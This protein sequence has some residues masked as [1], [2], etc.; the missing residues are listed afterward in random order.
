MNQSRHSLPFKSVA[1]FLAFTTVMFT[2]PVVSADPA[3][4]ELPTG[5]QSEFGN[6]SYSVNGNV[7][8][9][10]ST[11]GATIG[12]HEFF[13]VG[14][15]ATFIANID[16]AHLDRVRSG[17][18]SEIF[19][20]MQIN[21]GKFFL[22]N[23]GGVY[24]APGSQVNASGLVAS[25]L[26]INNQDFINGNYKFFQ[27]G[28]AASVVNDGSLYIGEHGLALLGGSVENRGLISA[29]ESSVVLASGK[30]A[31]LSFDGGLI[32][33]V[34]DK[35]TLQGT[36][37][38]DAVANSGIIRANGGKVVM[39]AE[40]ANSIFDK[41]V[42]N[43][44][45]VEANSVGSK[46]GSVELSSMKSSGIVANSGTISAQGQNAGEKGGKVVIEGE[47]VGLME[48]STVN[49][50]GD[51]GAG[52]VNVGGGFQGKDASIRNAEVT[53]VDE[54]ASIIA[55]AVNTGNGGDVV[56]WANDANRYF[57]TI[58]ARGGA[59]SGD[60]GDVEVS[61]KEFLAF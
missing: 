27:N 11:G 33:V 31:T 46:T 36:G 49:V 12:S 20:N 7:G 48:N 50:S 26:D 37:A 41:L 21:G 55:D 9:L 61:G 23:S 17:S 42:N 58:S 16:T 35:Q 4:N 45:I 24:F 39:T 60:G 30:E 19:G 47:K 34:V 32:S 25:T 5:Y 56:V 3:P 13:N 53:Y 18:P 43:R 28:S 44:G 22:V 54:T 38:K 29:N 6:S 1:A 57:G 51:A 15:N 8:T 59:L 52:S 2:T 40:A 10:T 14:S